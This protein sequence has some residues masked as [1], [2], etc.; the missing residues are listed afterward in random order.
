MAAEH[1]RGKLCSPVPGIKTGRLRVGRRDDHPAA[2][3][4]SLP[5]GV[6]SAE[7]PCH[8]GGVGGQGCPGAGVQRGE[9][10]EHDLAARDGPGR[11]G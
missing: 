10:C 9:R 4:A 2:I 5:P 6:L 1:Q 11:H 3:G 8:V 7:E